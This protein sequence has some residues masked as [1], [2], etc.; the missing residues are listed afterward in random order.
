M[1]NRVRKISYCYVMVPSRS[2]QGAKVLGALKDAGVNLLAYSGFPARG[3]K[4]QLDLVAERIAPIAR[5]AR[6][7]GWRLS[8][9][10]RGFLIQGEDRLGA[11]H[12]QIQKLADAGINIVA[13]DAVTAGGGRYGMI[14][15]VKPRD[16]A[17]AAR[18]LKAK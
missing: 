9:T 3:G 16:Y 8:R 17:Q 15:W 6:K 18:V 11:V 7:H 1:A 14:L 4:A 5:V 12:R 2:G 13:G 10:K